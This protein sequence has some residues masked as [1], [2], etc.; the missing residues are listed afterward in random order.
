MNSSLSTMSGEYHRL[1]KSTEL[2][3]Q[4]REYADRMREK[5]GDESAQ[6][7][8]LSSLRKNHEQK[9]ESSSFPRHITF[10]YVSQVVFAILGVVIPLTHGSWSGYLG[11]N[12]NILAI[13]LFGVG[14]AT[15]FGYIISEVWVAM[16]EKQG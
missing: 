4:D 8:L 15:T 3:Q 2:A 5:L 11:D 16:H 12:S 10:G 6:I 9:L 13:V 7:H 1:P 14:L